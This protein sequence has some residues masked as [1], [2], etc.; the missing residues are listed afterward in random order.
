VIWSCKIRHMWRMVSCVHLALKCG[1][2][3]FEAGLMAS[4]AI[5][6]LDIVVKHKRGRF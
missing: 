2:D 5:R 4:I 6:V 1:F 3:A